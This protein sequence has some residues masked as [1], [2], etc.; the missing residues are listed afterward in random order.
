MSDFKCICIACR[1]EMKN[2]M[3]DGL[4]PDDGICFYSKGHY[5]STVFDPMDG[6]YLEICVCDECLTKAASEGLVYR[7]EILQLAKY[8]TEP[9][10]GETPT[11]EV[12]E[13]ETTTDAAV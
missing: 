2:Y 3:S 10:D 11:W 1:K 4:Q 13:A 7:A 9:W 5:G 6:S 12:V 8:K